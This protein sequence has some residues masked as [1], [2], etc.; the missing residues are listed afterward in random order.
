MKVF[1]GMSG[2]VDSSV[3]AM[4]LKKQGFDVEGVSLLMF[5][6]RIARKEKNPR[7]CCSLESVKDAARTAQ[8]IGIP[9]RVADARDI[10]IEKVIE[11]FALAYS[12]GRTPNPCILCNRHVKFPVLLDAAIK[13]GADLIA[14]G[15]Y[16]RLKATPEGPVLSRAADPKK[17]QSY[18]LYAQDKEELKRLA[19]PLGGLKKEDVRRIAREAGLP[20]FDRPESQEICFIE[21]RDYPAMVRELCPAALAGGPI[22]DET[23]KRIGTHDGICR[24]TI[25]QRKGLGGH[26]DSHDP[27]PLYVYRIDAAEN[28]VYAGD[29]QKAFAREITVGE[30][31]WLMD[32]WDGIL[33]KGNQGEKG[34]RFFGAGV[35]VR[36]MMRPAP[37]SVYVSAFS[38]TARVV[39]D[40]PQWAAAPGQSAVFYDGDAV[41]GGGIILEKK[42]EEGG[43]TAGA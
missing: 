11:P 13:G 35:K 14:T 12:K 29:R 3:A 22:L 31:S 25:G 26:R 16:A 41:I 10:F 6:T 4:L 17:D 19:L 42:E 39:F 20:V 2:G 30:L 32:G 21:G 7:S 24:Y 40:S 8:A 38:G 23:G 27:K 33:K 37:A 36:S 28:A 34:F 43:K 1:V 15:H 18:V 5:E 9:H